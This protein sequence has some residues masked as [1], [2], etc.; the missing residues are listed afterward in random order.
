MAPP[1]GTP[2]YNRLDRTGIRY[3]KLIALKRNDAY[4][5]CR[6]DCGN[7]CSVL[8]TNLANYKKGNRGCRHCSHRKDITG[9]RVGLLVALE[10]EAGAVS[11]RHPLWLFQCDCGNTIQ[12]TVREFNVG[13]LRSCGCHAN[14]YASWQ[15]M[16][17]RCYDSKNIRF[18]HYGARGIKV[19]KRWHSFDNFI[20]DMGERPKR[21]TLS[22]NHAEKDY[23]PS[24][25]IWEHITKNIADT[26]FGKPTKA[27]RKKGA[28][29][30]F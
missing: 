10:R 18:K 27:G 22:R 16:M 13:M 25:C 19:C 28:L 15:F 7:E 12:G 23:T 26:C 1:K 5:I 3:G 4:W 11:G 29:P 24:N 20:A 2:A 30:R 14:A 6:C 17:A 9:N 8:S 21:H